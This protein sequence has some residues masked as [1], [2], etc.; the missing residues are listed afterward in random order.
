MILSPPGHPDGAGGRLGR[1]SV[2]KALG[3]QQARTGREAGAL[4]VSLSAP[5]DRGVAAR[6]LQ[7]GRSRLS[8][9]SPSHPIPSCPVPSRAGR[10]A[11]PCCTG[12]TT[13]TTVG[14]SGRGR[15]G[16]QRGPAGSTSRLG[17]AAPAPSGELSELKCFAVRASRLLS[18]HSA[19]QAAERCPCVRHRPQSRAG[20]GSGSG[21][22]RSRWGVHSLL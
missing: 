13:S 11:E 4:Q 10:R 12:D 21:L 18:R 3:R 19:R 2:T 22:P 14:N 5:G 15:R 8:R 16:G 1:A 17:W 20:L 6:R 7:I 9:P